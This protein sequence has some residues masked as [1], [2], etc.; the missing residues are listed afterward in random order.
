MQ[1]VFF[2]VVSL[3]PLLFRVTVSFTKCYET[4]LVSCYTDEIDT[5]AMEEK[6]FSDTKVH[7]RVVQYCCERWSEFVTENSVSVWIAHW[8]LVQKDKSSSSLVGMANRPS[9]RKP[10]MISDFRWNTASPQ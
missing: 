6:H 2:C 1:F 7:R 8:S 10:R 9:L 5:S 3:S 4:L